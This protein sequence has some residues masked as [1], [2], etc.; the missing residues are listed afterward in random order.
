MDNASIGAKELTSKET[1]TEKTYSQKNN[2]TDR[3]AD[4]HKN[5]KIYNTK[6]L[7]S[8]MAETVLITQRFHA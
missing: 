2:L 8:H 3:K 1:N 6:N 4:R 5:R 7:I